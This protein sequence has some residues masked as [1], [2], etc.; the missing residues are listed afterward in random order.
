MPAHGD[1]PGILS[2]LW[3]LGF[4][5][6]CLILFVLSV[7]AVPA[8]VAA[9]FYAIAEFAQSGLFGVFIA[10]LCLLVSTA[11]ARVGWLGLQTSRELI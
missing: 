1:A 3:L 2:K 5:S 11:L 7:V 4:S 8:S 10:V 6:L 9:V